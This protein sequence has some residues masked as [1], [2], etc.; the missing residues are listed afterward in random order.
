MSKL[1][2]NWT[3]RRTVVICTLIYCGLVIAYLAALGGDTRLNETIVN[4]L[5]FVA[6]STLGSYVF[7]ATWDDR[8][9][10]KFKGPGGPE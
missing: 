10:M 9:K 5:G 8:N 3:V 7:G 1:D 2:A 6:M 4:I